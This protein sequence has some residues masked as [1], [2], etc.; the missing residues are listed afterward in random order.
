MTGAERDKTM[1]DEMHL[2]E[3]ELESM[4]DELIEQ[5]AEADLANQQETEIIRTPRRSA[6][7]KT[8]DVAPDNRPP[9]VRLQ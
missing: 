4:A 9:E 6:K 5:A 7:K 8:E 2:T 1:N 3:E